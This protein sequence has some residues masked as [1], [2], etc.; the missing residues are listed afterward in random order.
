MLSTIVLMIASTLVRMRVV[1]VTDL[2]ASAHEARAQLGRIGV[3]SGQVGAARWHDARDAARRIEEMGYSAL[4]LNESPTGREPFTCAALLLQ[5]TERLAV[6]TGIANIW[7]RDPVA[8]FNATLALAEAHPGRFVLGLGVSHKPIVGARGHDYEK[9]IRAMRGY[10][11][12]MDTVDSPWAMPA[13]PIP[14]VLAAL[15]ARMLE[16]ARERA[17]G[18]HPYFMPVE[19]TMRARAA[20]GP[21]RLLSPELA[22]VVER[23]ATRARERAR[24]YVGR[25]LSL[26]NYTNALRELGFGDEDFAGLGSDRLVDAIV[27][28]GS[29]DAVAERVR[30]HWDAGADH[31]AVQVVG[32]E[33]TNSLSELERLAAIVIS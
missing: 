27:A 29:A 13:R 6:A 9:P 7:V 14:R 10:L 31:V 8:A 15:R 25:Y 28:W 4:W 5:S 16:L 33:L 19:H 26:P 23:D 18:A 24:A 2:W 32:T 20:L 30:Q 21:D 12:A 1:A 3:W 11:E 22:V 17:A